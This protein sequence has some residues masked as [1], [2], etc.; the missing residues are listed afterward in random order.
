[1]TGEGSTETPDGNQAGSTQDGDPEKSGN[2]DDGKTEKPGNPDDSDESDP[3]NPENTDEGDS[4]NPEDTEGGKSDG[5]DKPG[6]GETGTP[7]GEP[8]GEKP[9][10]GNSGDGGLR[11]EVEPLIRLCLGV[12]C[13]EVDSGELRLM[14]DALLARERIK[15][16]EEHLEE[17]ER[18]HAA[19]IA[20]IRAA[21]EAETA[22]IRGEMEALKEGFADVL[23]REKA[24]SYGAGEIAG[25]NTQIRAILR[26]NEELPDLPIGGEIEEKHEKS[27]FDI[28]WNA[29]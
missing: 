23:E 17:R 9:G 7:E 22:R 6:D 19:E 25:R 13:G 4:G 10:E 18:A 16:L 11:R 5:S 29:R 1:M 27:I 2:P 12:V 21:A 26:K 14:R 3:G 28:A 24:A 20:G 15:E 8:E